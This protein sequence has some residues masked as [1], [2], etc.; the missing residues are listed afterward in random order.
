MLDTMVLL[1]LVGPAEFCFSSV[2][3]QHSVTR[4]PSSP[5]ARLGFSPRRERESRAWELDLSVVLG[6]THK[7]RVFGPFA[8]HVSLHEVLK[9]DLIPECLSLWYEGDLSVIHHTDIPRNESEQ[10]GHIDGA[11]AGDHLLLVSEHGSDLRPADLLCH[12]VQVL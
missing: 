5:S 12:G 10:R 11:F 6:I 4:A 2:D 9:A 1:R 3:L 8:H 7:D